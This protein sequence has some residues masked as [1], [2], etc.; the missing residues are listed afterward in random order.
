MTYDV[1]ARGELGVKNI[2]IEGITVATN[3]DMKRQNDITSAARYRMTKMF[4]Q[5]ARLIT[6]KG[7]VADWRVR[8]GGAI[9]TELTV[10]DSEGIDRI[11]KQLIVLGWPRKRPSELGPV[12]TH[13]GRGLLTIEIGYRREEEIVESYTLVSDWPMG[14]IIEKR[15][16]STVS[17]AVGV[18]EVGEAIREAKII[19]EGQRVEIKARIEGEDR[20][21]RELGRYVRT[22]MKIPG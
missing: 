6:A 4:G 15:W 22:Y 7:S 18:L 1:I 14:E 12:I 5:R 20:I 11:Y 21:G 3:I 2:K 19:R 17:G 9:G 16:N 13:N 10:T 8:E